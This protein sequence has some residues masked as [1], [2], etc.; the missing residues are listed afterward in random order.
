MSMASGVV[1]IRPDLSPATWACLKGQQSFVRES[2]Y[3][4]TNFGFAEMIFGASFFM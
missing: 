2:G 4:F 1:V 3:N